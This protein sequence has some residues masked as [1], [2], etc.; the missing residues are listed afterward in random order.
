MFDFNHFNH[1]NHFK[2]LIVLLTFMSICN[3]KC[4]AHE[5]HVSICTMDYN[6]ANKSIEL[7]FKL[8]AHDFEKAILENNKADLKLGSPK[9]LSSANVLITNYITDHFLISFAD[10]SRRLKFIGKEVELDESL[11]LYFEIKNVSLNNRMTVVN[12]ILV[13]TCP[14]QENILYFNLGKQVLS[15]VFNKNR[16]HKEIELTW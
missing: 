4:I 16:T 3:L 1:F 12:T 2:Q 13:Q 9:E 11:Y 6:R 14:A 8:I 15:E 7:T 10:S 5:Y